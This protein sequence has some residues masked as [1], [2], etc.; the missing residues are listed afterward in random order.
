MAQKIILDCD[1]GVDDTMAILYAA[2]H[3]EIERL[4]VG[5]VW[6]NV[7]I[8]TATPQLPTHRRDCRPRS[9]SFDWPGGI[10]A[11]SN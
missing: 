11:R 5:S 4:A 9:R 7:D 10:R 6:G 1:T 3:P 2:I 8:E